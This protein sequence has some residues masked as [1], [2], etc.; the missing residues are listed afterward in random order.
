MTKI[1]Y[2]S[3]VLI[4]Y[5]FLDS[6]LMKTTKIGNQYNLDIL[7]QDNPCF[8]KYQDNPNNHDY[9]SVIAVVYCEGE[10]PCVFTVTGVSDENSVL[11]K[12][13]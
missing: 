9:C 5:N 8:N 2:L 4:E 1:K 13:K 6:N 10:E 7:Q 3:N 11:L 12:E